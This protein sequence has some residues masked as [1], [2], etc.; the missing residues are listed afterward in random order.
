MG[1]ARRVLAGARACQCN[2]RIELTSI[3]VTAIAGASRGLGRGLTRR[4]LV[5][6]HQPDRRSE[7]SYGEGI[8]P[9][10]LVASAIAV[11]RHRYGPARCFAAV[12]GEAV[13][14]QPLTRQAI[15]LWERGARTVPAAALLVAAELVDM[16]LEELMAAAA[17][18]ASRPSLRMGP[19]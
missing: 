9:R 4:R 17:R 15:Y 10:T 5:A 1:M 16:D 3:T 14:G 8:D 19:S 18:F 13:D 11:A 2:A 12:L 6:D 7:A